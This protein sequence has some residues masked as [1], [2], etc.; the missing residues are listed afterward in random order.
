ML[1][2]Q[3]SSYIQMV[4]YLPLLYVYI[5]II[6]NH[7]YT[8]IHNDYINNLIEFTKYFLILI[9]IL[10]Y[11]NIWNNIYCKW[12]KILGASCMLMI[13]IQSKDSVVQK[14]PCRVASICST[15]TTSDQWRNVRIKFKRNFLSSFS[16]RIW[17][18]AG[19]KM[20]IARASE[21]ERAKDSVY[22]RHIYDSDSNHGESAQNHRIYMI[23]YNS[24]LGRMSKRVILRVVLVYVLPHVGHVHGCCSF[25]YV[26]VKC[27][28]MYV[29]WSHLTKAG[30]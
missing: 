23:S 26:F 27:T 6:I 10:K 8:H 11:I 14:R 15:S 16:S 9:S 20:N 19:A 3:M 17:V 30:E 7:T 2:Y 5:N 1:F 29:Y 28:V 22:N 12:L 18:C 25:I 13:Y 4:K 24:G 21:R